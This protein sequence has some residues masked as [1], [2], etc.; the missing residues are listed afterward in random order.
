MRD[1][2]LLAKDL[3]KDGVE[4]Q[5]VEVFEMLTAERCS[6]FFQGNLIDKFQ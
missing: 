6:S 1:D 4:E 5:N 3:L 2:V